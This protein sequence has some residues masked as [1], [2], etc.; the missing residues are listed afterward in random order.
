MVKKIAVLWDSEVDMKGPAPFDKTKWNT[1]YEVFSEEAEKN[2]VEFY[3][4]N[5]KM[6]NDSS[7]KEAYIYNEGEWERVENV[8]ID[9]VFDKY[10]FDKDTKELKKKIAKQVPVINKPELEELCKD[11][12]ATYEKFPEFVPETRKATK[13]NIKEI[14]ERDGIT[15]VKPRGDFGGRGVQ[16]IEDIEDLEPVNSEENIV[17]EYVD[18]TKGIPN[19][20][21]NSPHDIRSI[22]VSGQ[23]I[24][25]FVRVPDEGLVSN[26]MQ[27]GDMHVFDQKEYSDEALEIINRVSEALKEFEPNVF[28]V[29]IVYNQK[30]NPRVVELNSKPSLSFHEED[31]YKKHKLKVIKQAI[32]IFKEF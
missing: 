17:Q 11:K 27:G 10:K 16:I 2:K 9:G 5:Y 30:G 19:T 32:E 12:L 15:V 20:R 22:V 8:E 24:A 7:L 28:S 1:D 18:T 26:V 13:E 25:S 3:L 14:L 4:S 23:L 6:Y 29:D 31:K 21:Y